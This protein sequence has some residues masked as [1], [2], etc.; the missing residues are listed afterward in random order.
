M[1]SWV[2][3]VRDLAPIVVYSYKSNESDFIMVCVVVNELVLFWPHACGPIEALGS[4]ECKSF[5]G[6]A[7]TTVIGPWTH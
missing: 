7:I 4:L 2:T 5:H 3:M 1:S 6:K